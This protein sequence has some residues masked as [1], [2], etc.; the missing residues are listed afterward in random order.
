MRAATRPTQTTEAPSSRPTMAAAK[1]WRRGG[2]DCSGAVPRVTRARPPR[3]PPPSGG[4]SDDLVAGGEHPVGA[5]VHAVDEDDPRGAGFETETRDQRAHGGGLG[6]QEANA[7]CDVPR[8]LRLEAGE[9]PC[10]DRCRPGSSCP[11]CTTHRGGDSPARRYGST[12]RGRSADR[13]VDRA[14]RRG[15]GC[16]RTTTSEGRKP[17]RGLA[18]RTARTARR[19]GVATDGRDA[20]LRAV[21]VALIKEI[22]EAI[23]RL[24]RARVGDRDARAPR[25]PAQPAQGAGERLPRAF[26][27]TARPALTRTPR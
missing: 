3:Q 22:D 12:P 6:R 2:A 5:G 26:R 27:R 21:Q 7:R 20:A 14:A 15:D 18:A 13:G 4:N 17:A 11:D 19:K 23:S 9:Q 8:S 10:G 1:R 24:E 25:D 16:W